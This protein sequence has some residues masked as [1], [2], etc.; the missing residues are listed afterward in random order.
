MQD[1]ETGKTEEADLA[2]MAGEKSVEMDLAFN[3]SSYAGSQRQPHTNG[4][5]R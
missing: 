5:N 4:K 2:E 3:F 1:A